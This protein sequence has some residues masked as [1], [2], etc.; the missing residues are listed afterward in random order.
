MTNQEQDIQN[1]IAL[2]D[3]KCDAGVS[4]IQVNVSEQIEPG[5]VKDAHHHGRCDVGSVFA[6][7]MNNV[8]CD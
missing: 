1:I 6:T 4:R 8:S 2:L 5:S 3:G 7:G